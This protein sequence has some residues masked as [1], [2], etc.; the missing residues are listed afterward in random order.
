[1]S[2][3]TMGITMTMG[4]I[5]TMGSIGGD[6]AI[7]TAPTSTMT[8]I[9]ILGEDETIIA[10][11]TAGDIGGI[12]I[13]PGVAAKKLPSE[14]PEEQEHHSDFCA[15]DHDDPREM[16]LYEKFYFFSPNRHHAADQKKAER[17]GGCK[18]KGKGEKAE[19]KNSRPQAE[20]FERKWDEPPEKDGPVLVGLEL[21]GDFLKGS[22]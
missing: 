15:Y 12:T 7:I 6:L 11:I 14:D 19:M 10:I 8:G 18:A 22:G 4:I 17:A 13:A 16:A 2:D 5:T 3:P 21:G 20:R 1:M 9:T